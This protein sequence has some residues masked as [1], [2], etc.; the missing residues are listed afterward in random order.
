MLG[1]RTAIAEVFAAIAVPEDVHPQVDAIATAALDWASACEIAGDAQQRARL[2][3]A[4]FDRLAARIFPTETIADVSLLTQWTV[5][6]FA[7]DDQQDE[8]APG[9]GAVR[10]VYDGLLDILRNRKTPQT[11]T[12]K[13]L[14]DL[15]A[16]TAPR[17]SVHWQDRFIHHLER[18]RDAFL[19]QADNRSTGRVPTLAEYPDLRRRANGE[20]MFDLFEVVRGAEIPEH[21]ACTR[22]WQDLFAASNDVTAWCND[23]LSV[24]REERC[25]DTTNYVTVHSRALGCDRA[26]AIA[27]VGHRIRQRLLE[28]QALEP[29]ALAE[30]RRLVGKDHDAGA[31]RMARVLVELPGTHL[32]WLLESGRY[33]PGLS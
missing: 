4:R 11:T 12:E 25:G 30:A 21:V 27:H 22:P 18:H 23:I 19:T 15:W 7:L 9:P 26:S 1:T 5:W 14:V 13:A 17:M 31:S 8:S 33:Q 28:L 10:T 6:F 2:A 16:R 32:G 20:H 24:D 3:A 29:T